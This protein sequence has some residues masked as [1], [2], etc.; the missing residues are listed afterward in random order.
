MKAFEDIVAVLI[1]VIVG[2]RNLVSTSSTLVALVS[3]VLSSR[4]ID[5]EDHEKLWLLFWK[6]GARLVALLI[7]VTWSF[8]WTRLWPQIAAFLFFKSFFLLNPAQKSFVDLQNVY[9]WSG[10]IDNFQSCLWP[11]SACT[12]TIWVKMCENHSVASAKKKPQCDNDDAKLNPPQCLNKGVKQQNSRDC[13]AAAALSIGARQWIL[14]EVKGGIHILY[15]LNDLFVLFVYLSSAQQLDRTWADRNMV[16]S[17]FIVFIIDYF[18][19]K[20]IIILK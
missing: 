15:I 9:L 6:T 16:Y 7:I 3:L 11:Q 19:Q 5:D 18:P 8:I 14:Q 17:C 1:S 10:A 12:V 13:R 20:V 4:Y 2:H